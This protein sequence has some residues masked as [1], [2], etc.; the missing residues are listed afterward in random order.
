MSNGKVKQGRVDVSQSASPVAPTSA[1]SSSSSTLVRDAGTATPA[2]QPSPPKASKSTSPL[3]WTRRPNRILA[4]GQEALRRGCPVDIKAAKLGHLPV[5]PM[6]AEPRLTFWALP[7]KRDWRAAYDEGQLPH[8][9]VLVAYARTR[10]RAHLAAIAA[11]GDDALATVQSFS[12][13]AEWRDVWTHILGCPRDS[14]TEAAARAAQIVAYARANGRRPGDSGTLATSSTDPMFPG[15][16]CLTGTVAVR[17]ICRKG[18]AMLNRRTSSRRGQLCVP[19]SV[20]CRLKTQSC[21][22]PAP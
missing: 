1:A 6:P 11:M 15:C 14:L 19:L 20:Q 17:R 21:S 12:G 5:V 9:D 22:W 3:D 7:M 18:T 2:P 10:A 13:D 16:M 8:W 4:S